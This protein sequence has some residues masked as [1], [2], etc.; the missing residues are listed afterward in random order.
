M[1]KRII[2]ALDPSEYSRKALDA[3]IWL[4]LQHEAELTGICVLDIP[5]IESSLGSVPLGASYYA[6]ELSQVR[7]KQAETRIKDLLENFDKKCSEAEVKFKSYKV[8]GLPS[9]EIINAAKYYDVLI[10]GK[11]TYFGLESLD[12]EGNS[13]DEILDYSITPIIAIPK[14]FEINTYK[15]KNRKVLVAFDGSLP[16]CRALQ[17]WSQLAVSGSIEVKLVMSGK[18]TDYRDHSLDEAEELLNAHGLMNI[19]KFGTEMDIK[20]VINQEV[21]DDYDVIVIGA[22]SKSSLIRFFTGSFTNYV[23]NKSKNL[24]F[25]GQ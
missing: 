6:R 8:Q 12:S 5:G 20:D 19:V 11:R 17:R 3:S 13:F 22:H 14:E 24:I 1:V 25:I 16:S 9:S 7:I 21:L 4:A 10:I 15:L 23:I 18:D 2:V